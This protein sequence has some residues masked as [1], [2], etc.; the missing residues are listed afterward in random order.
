MKY[1]RINALQAFTKYIYN[2]KELFKTGMKL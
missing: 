2:N 1:K